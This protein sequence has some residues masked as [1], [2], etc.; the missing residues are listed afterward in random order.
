MIALVRF[1]ILVYYLYVFSVIVLF[2]F[3]LPISA[4]YHNIKNNL[5]L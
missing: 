5:F 1:Q 3:F 2:C 4:E